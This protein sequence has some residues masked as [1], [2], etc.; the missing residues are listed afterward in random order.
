MQSVMAIL[1][2][3]YKTL[4]SVRTG[5][6]L[7]LVVVLF[8][9]VGTVILQRPTSEPD[10]IERSYSPSTLL[11]LDRLGLT[12]IYH[13]WYFVTLLGLVSISIIFVSI[14][15][16]QAISRT[17]RRFS[18]Y[19]APASGDSRLRRCHRTVRSRA[20]LSQTRLAGGT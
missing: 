16:L 13:T 18:R 8:S 2:K 5:I 20:R 12:D 1:Q 14:D 7:L 3:I 11:W 19:A 6:I 9:A 10:V 15:L 4:A 17:C